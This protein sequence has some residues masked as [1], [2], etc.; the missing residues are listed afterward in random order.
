MVPILLASWLLARLSPSL[1]TRP[2]SV[3]R[4]AMLTRLFR[5]PL[6][7]LSLST[8]NLLHHIWVCHVLI[9]FF[10]QRGGRG[11]RGPELHPTSFTFSP[12]W[13]PGLSSRATEQ[14]LPGQRGA[15]SIPDNTIFYSQLPLRVHRTGCPGDGLPRGRAAC[16]LWSTLWRCPVFLR[17]AS[18]QYHP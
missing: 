6:P 8:I 9:S 7:V 1:P 3:Y 18:L 15:S 17:K 14:S 12:C 5:M 13:A 2:G 4:A 16:R 11:G 10:I